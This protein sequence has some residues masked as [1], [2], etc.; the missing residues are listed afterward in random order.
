MDQRGW[1][2]N[3]HGALDPLGAEVQMSKPA[4]VGKVDFGQVR[5]AFFQDQP[6][7]VK[8]IYY[9]LDS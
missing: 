1:G 3:A 4:I 5:R 8:A 9:R 7:I 6:I 2:V